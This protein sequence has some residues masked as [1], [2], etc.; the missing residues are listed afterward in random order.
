MRR[1]IQRRLIV[2]FSLIGVTVISAGS[3]IFYNV[4]LLSG[5][6]RSLI[7]HDSQ[8]LQNAQKLQKIVFDAETGQ[9]GYVIT[10]DDKFLEPY[11]LALEN[12]ELAYKKELALVS[13]NPAQVERIRQIQESFYKW[14]KEAAAPEIA[15]RK[16]SSIEYAI[17]LIKV[18]TGKGILDNI[19]KEFTEFIRIENNLEQQRYKTAQEIEASSESVILWG[20]LLILIVLILTT[21]ILIRSIIPPINKLRTAADAIGKGELETKI[22][23]EGNDEISALAA[24][25][26]K[27]SINLR[28]AAV[29]EKEVHWLQEGKSRFSD[30]IISSENAKDFGLKTVNEIVDYLGGVVGHFY[31]VTEDEKSLILLAAT[32]MDV[33]DDAQLIP[34]NEGIV[35]RAASLSKT[36]IV[37]DIKD[38]TI[39]VDTAIGRINPT[40]I[41]A[42]PIISE[43]RVSAVVELAFSKPIKEVYIKYLDSIS[44]SIDSELSSIKSKDR[45][46]ELFQLSELNN[47]KLQNANKDLEMFS[48]SVSHDLKAPLRALQGFSKNLKERYSDDFDERGVRWLEFIE[49]NAERMDTLIS[50]ILAFSRITRA[51]LKN[52]EIDMTK[53]VKEVFEREKDDYTNV[54][55]LKLNDLHIAWGDTSMIEIVWQNLIGNALKYSSKRKVIIIEISSIELKDSIEYFIK[56]NGAGFDMRHYNKLFGVFKR[57]HGNDEFPGTG[58]GL[59]NVDQILK[60]H[61]GSIRAESEVDEGATF[62]IT[63][64]KHKPDE[65]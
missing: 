49:S 14:Q 30:T 24:S 36:Q 28:S 59:A 4:N 34:F 56:D 21:A 16:D 39:Y 23:I 7:E 62:T 65:K 1:N 9:R 2:T 45:I 31:S 63:L 12:F 48:Y 22:D 60:K 26:N 18:G 57:L 46:D 55:Q 51:K 17:K 54:V 44:E 19:R 5:Q 8:V 50:D 20:I 11:N 13:D 3:L 42:C 15:A 32:N 64:P 43:N 27:M 37:N 40:Q 61:G 25:F 41:L 35:G 52:R 53:T 6:F 38:D 33:S 47:E 58:I 29:K 10:G